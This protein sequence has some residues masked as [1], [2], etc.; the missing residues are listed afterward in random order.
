MEE[1]KQIRNS[2]L[3][4]TLIG[5]AFVIII[6][7]LI[8]KFVGEG[9]VNSKD[10]SR[11]RL[12]YSTKEWAARMEGEMDEAK[13]IGLI[14]A[15][16]AKDSDKTAKE[17]AKLAVEKSDLKTI[18][19]YNEDKRA[20]NETG[21]RIVSL[22]LSDVT[23]PS[24]RE[25]FV[26]YSTD[27]EN[28]DTYVA[29]MV[30]IEGKKECVLCAFSFKDVSSKFYREGYEE[31][32]FLA[33]TDKEG[34]IYG[35]FLNHQDSDS[36]FLSGEN[37]LDNIEESVVSRE[38]F[39]VFKVRLFN[40]KAS[41]LEA[42]YKED[43]RTIAAAPIGSSTYCLYYGVR[44]SQIDKMSSGFFANVK[45][46]VIKL[47]VVI[48][49]F[50]AFVVTT[51]VFNSVKYKERGKVLEDKA[52]TDLLTELNNKSAT[53]RKIQEYIEAYPNGRAMM[54]ILDI[55]NFKK[56]NDT[57]GHAFGDT[58]LRTLGKEIKTEFRMTDIIGRTGG[59]EFMV[60]LKDVN[61]DLTVEREANRITKFFHDFKAGGD[62]VKY[63]ATASIGAAIY[64]DD[65]KTFKDLYVAADQ[66]L[67]KA[68]K[69]GKN[70]LA[71]Y[72][73]DVKR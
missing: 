69:R 32:S 6:F 42:V 73:E 65:A 1:N 12:A 10:Y 48:L 22:D 54:F 71:F 19:F 21:N 28:P 72:N 57:M 64:P 2:A 68:K 41:A 17:Y 62:Y 43:A 4:W 50:A 47:S 55:D 18:I 36:M 46:T 15:A 49:V 29:A 23:I 3:S 27:E 51:L 59:D 58:L 60:F 38:D 16:L 13:S 31:V 63:S 11:D 40:G 5:A 25:F 44:Q 66:A 35:K 52:D 67:Y 8:V 39:N 7:F 30:P 34:K 53:E 70:Q 14:V 26:L 61:D 9:K 45:N 56:I 24:K 37:V 20:V 33:L